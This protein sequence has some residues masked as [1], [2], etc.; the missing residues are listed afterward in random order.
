MR[1][2]VLNLISLFLDIWT[3]LRRGEAVIITTVRRYD[4]LS[5]VVKVTPLNCSLSDLFIATNA[6]MAHCKKDL[7]L[8]KPKGDI[9][10]QNN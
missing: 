9:S 7:L 1:G 4:K 8:I 3:A 6:L 10:W 5:D 2:G